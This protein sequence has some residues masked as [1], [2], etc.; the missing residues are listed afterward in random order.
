MTSAESVREQLRQSEVAKYDD[1]YYL[2]HYWA[3]DLPDRPGHNALSY[4]DPDHHDRFDFLAKT[5][6]D[7]FDFCTF[8]DAGC[9]TG[10]L[11]LR[12]TELGAEPCGVDVSNAA[13]KLYDATPTCVARRPKFDVGYLHALPFA[14]RS[15]DLTWC[16]DVLEHIPLF[17][18]EQSIAKL[19]RVT[20]KH[21]VMTINMDN[22]YKYHPTILSR[23]TWRA[24]FAE[25]DQLIEQEAQRERLQTLI[26]RRYSEYELFVYE[27]A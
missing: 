25:S 18:I 21:L 3:E 19:V 7:E 17:D 22:P 27:R 14:D 1:A 11:M 20:R 5:L 23:E 10:L 24:L 16:S 13:K 15:F 4:H 9:G 8:L 6:V 12:L 2:E 26:N